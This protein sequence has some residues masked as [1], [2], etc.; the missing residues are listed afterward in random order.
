MATNDKRR[1]PRLVHHAQVQ[2]YFPN[3]LSE[4]LEMHD[5]SNAGMFILCAKQNLP[6][7][8]EVL[9]VKT[10]EIEDAVLR[11]VKVI[12]VVADQGFAVQFV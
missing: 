5:F 6:A 3:G 10:L 8:G 7:T 4:P 11:E 2:V 9:Q 12:R 1:H